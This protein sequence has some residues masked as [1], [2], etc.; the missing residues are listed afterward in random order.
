MI[1]TSTV[2][3]IRQGPVIGDLSP[4]GV[5]GVVW[6][7]WTSDGKNPIVFERSD[8]FG[9]SFQR[10][11][12]ID[13]AVSDPTWYA[14]GTG[15]ALHD[16]KFGPAGT[17]WIL[18]SGLFV[19]DQGPL[20]YSFRISRSTDGGAS[21]KQLFGGPRR[22][23]PDGTP[24]LA[25]APDGTVMIICDEDGLKCSRFAG[26]DFTVRE[27][28][29]I[30]TAPYAASKWNTA[31]D[32]T[33]GRV[34]V[35][36][37]GYRFVS[38][39]SYSIQFC[40]ASPDTGHSFGPPVRVDTTSSIQVGGQVL[41]SKDDS[42]LV[43][44]GANIGQDQ[45]GAVL[46]RVLASFSSDRGNTFCKL[47]T[48]A[49]SSA[50]YFGAAVAISKSAGIAAVWERGVRAAPYAHFSQLE[51]AHAPSFA[52]DF[53]AVGPVCVASY[54]AV[55]LTDSGR[56]VVFMT[57]FEGGVGRNYFARTDLINSADIG[58]FG[59]R[60]EGLVL[61]QNFPNPFNPSTTIRYDLPQKSM[62]QLTTYTILGQRVGILLEGE[63]AAGHH[64]V[65]FDG[66][67]V[68]PSGVYFY[69][70]QAGDLVEPR[71][72]YPSPIRTTP[73]RPLRELETAKLSDMLQ[74]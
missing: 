43:V 8:D 61:H 4:E 62:V 17:I 42:L 47:T 6:N 15:R 11:I 2:G 19:P 38:P 59:L 58:G 23:G 22:F 5:I 53:G 41:V 72:T 44:Y 13:S 49:D 40:S 21:F 64:E 65:K 30:L 45:D 31:V 9:V 46:M 18:W 32:P 67:G 20:E 63:Q 54:P 12:V 7:E 55:I 51:Y 69:R 66:A 74:D 70:L 1:D 57:Q 3:L 52:Q 28:T 60:P 37:E 10:F 29:P 48:L 71:E 26:G 56:I 14:P 27:D 25:I 24:R 39:V 73:K 50:G 36:W 16:F 33:S 35:G 68:P 34:Y